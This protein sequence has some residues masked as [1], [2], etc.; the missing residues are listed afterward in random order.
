[1]NWQEVCEHPS[2]QN[3]PFKLELNEVGKV[4]MSPVRVSFGE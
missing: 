2:L 1:M 3:L 4:I